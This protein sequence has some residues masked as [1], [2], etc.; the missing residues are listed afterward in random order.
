MSERME[1]ERKKGQEALQA[2]KKRIKELE[3]CSFKAHLSHIEEVK[4]LQI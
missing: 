4:E 3:G 2:V 1:E